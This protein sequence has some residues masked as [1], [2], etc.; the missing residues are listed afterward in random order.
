MKTKKGIN[1]DEL[2]QLLCEYIEAMGE[3]KQCKEAVVDYLMDHDA[4]DTLAEIVSDFALLLK[5]P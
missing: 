2:G 5:N 1:Y 3:A 4:F